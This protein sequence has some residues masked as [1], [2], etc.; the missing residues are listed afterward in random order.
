MHTEAADLNAVFARDVLDEGGFAGDFD[1]FFAGVAVLIE[2]ADVARSH[3]L[4][5]WDGDGV[6]G[7]GGLV[8]VCAERANKGMGN[9]KT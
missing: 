2:G 7:E 1:E 6:L 5:K 8:A 4:R 9:W 3:G